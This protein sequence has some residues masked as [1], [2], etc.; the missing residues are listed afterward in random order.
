MAISRKKTATKAKTSSAPSPAPATLA[1]KSKCVSPVVPVVESVPWAPK[2]RRVTFSVH[3]DPGSTVSLAGDF[4]N[5]DAAAK[6]M[7]D[8]NGTGE[9]SVTILLPPGQYE[10]KFV[11]NGA[12]CVDPECA[13][14]V[15]NSLGTLNSLRRVE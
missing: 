6:P 8:A 9:F 15:Q 11:I 1:S 7:T 2:T 4:N 14:W 13:D 12:W 3:A 10:Y 5:W